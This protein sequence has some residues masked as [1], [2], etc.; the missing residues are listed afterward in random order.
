MGFES[1]GDL[2][3]LP[4]MLANVKASLAPSFITND[5]GLNATEGG[6]FSGIEEP[7]LDGTKE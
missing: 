1:E 3:L 2:F 4:N 6:A 5:E 7:H